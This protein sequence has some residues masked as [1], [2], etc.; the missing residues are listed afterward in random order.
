MNVNF[1]RPGTPEFQRDLD[2]NM[3]FVDGWLAARQ[4]VSWVGLLRLPSG[5]RIL[6]S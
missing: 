6:W 1:N 4:Y 3:Q 2:K 5:K